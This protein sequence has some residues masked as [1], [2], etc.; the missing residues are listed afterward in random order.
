MPSCSAALFSSNYQSKLPMEALGKSALSCFVWRAAPVL[1][2]CISPS[3]T[4]VLAKARR[5]EFWLPN[6]VAEAQKHRK[7]RRSISG[8]SN[9]WESAQDQAN[10][11]VATAGAI[12]E[13]MASRIESLQWVH[14]ARE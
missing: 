8:V 5:S 13:R 1:A 4:G 10:K 7:D 3:S 2:S 14:A 9:Q 6:A 12:S 11:T